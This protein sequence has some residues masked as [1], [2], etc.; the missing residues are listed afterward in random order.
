M[1][2]FLKRLLVT[3]MLEKTFLFKTEYF[4]ISKMKNFISAILTAASLK[5]H[6]K[7]T[8]VARRFK[9]KRILLDTEFDRFYDF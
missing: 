2:I 9:K 8:R 4:I 7:Y 3:E 1:F 6:E 5:F